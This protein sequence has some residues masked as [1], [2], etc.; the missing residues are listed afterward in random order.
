MNGHIFIMALLA[1]IL[2]NFTHMSINVLSINLTLT[3]YHLN[4]KLFKKNPPRITVGDF[5]IKLLFCLLVS[6]F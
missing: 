1:V 2:K 5:F 6:V 3:K 4:I